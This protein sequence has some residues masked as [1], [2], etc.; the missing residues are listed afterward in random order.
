IAVPAAAAALAIR[1]TGAR[2]QHLDAI[3]RYG[4]HPIAW[5]IYHGVRLAVDYLGPGVIANTIVKP[6]GRGIRD[7]YYKIRG[8]NKAERKEKKDI[9]NKE[10]VKKREESGE[11]FA[12]ALSEANRKLKEMTNRLVFSSVLFLTDRAAPG[13]F[14]QDLLLDFDLPKGL[15]DLIGLTKHISAGPAYQAFKHALKEAGYECRLTPTTKTVV[16]ETWKTGGNPDYKKPVVVEDPN[17][18]TPHPRA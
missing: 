3:V 18:H 5:T 15:V 13:T 6:I 17:V 8:G 14:K 4:I 11:P 2:I 12:G 10:E 7:T 16:L 9:K 1:L